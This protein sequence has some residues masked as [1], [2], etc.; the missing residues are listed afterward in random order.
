MPGKPKMYLAYVLLA[1][2]SPADAGM[3]GRWLFAD[4]GTVIDIQ[5]CPGANGDLCAV[6]AELP[7]DAADLPP[8]QR[9]LLCGSRL[10][11]G[12]RPSHKAVEAKR[13]DGWIVDPEERLGGKEPER[14]PASL[15][16]ISENQARI[17]VRGPLDI[18]VE[19]HVL[20]RSIAPIAGCR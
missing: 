18:V 6:I 15:M 5:P 7:S 11:G 3:L 1:L 16:V 14:H 12:L 4:D 13:L 17:D 10:M 20:T 9:L 8:D 19:S 2:T